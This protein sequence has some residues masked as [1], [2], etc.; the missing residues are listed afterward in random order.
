MAF[1]S[2]F[3][4]YRYKRV[5]FGVTPAGDL[6]QRKT[7]KIFEE[8]PNIFGIID[9]ILVLGYDEDGRYNDNTVKSIAKMPRSE[10]K[11]KRPIFGEIF[12]RLDVN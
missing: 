10:S 4:R 9:D 2:Q 5:P 7:D 3:G 8:L 12:S 11:T 1:A 6:F